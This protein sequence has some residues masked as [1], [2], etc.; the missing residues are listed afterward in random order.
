MIPQ[1]LNAIWIW[2]PFGTTYPYCSWGEDL[3][4]F[5]GAEYVQ[6]LG[7]TSYEMNL[8]ISLFKRNRTGF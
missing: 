8:F 4:Y 6:L 3:C 2:N 5:P 7:G 1:L